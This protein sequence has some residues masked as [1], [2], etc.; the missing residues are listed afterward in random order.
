MLG[1]IHRLLFGWVKDAAGEEGLLEVRRRAGI[2]DDRVFRMNEAYADDEW[3]TLFETA[4]EFLCLTQRQAERGFAEAFFRD[5][6]RRFPAW[7]EMSRSG[8][9]F[10]ERQPAIHNSFA[11]GLIDPNDRAQVNDKFRVESRPGSLVTRY[12]S[13]NDMCGVYIALAELVIDHYG[14]NASIHER[15]CQRRGDDECEI[16]VVEHSTEPSP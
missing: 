15:K 12:S 7:F 5:A 11:T 3:R 16:V 13:V 2:L 8:R 9:K 10:L 4:R 1:L 14:D 6:L